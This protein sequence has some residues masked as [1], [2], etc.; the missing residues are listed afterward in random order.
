MPFLVHS[1]AFGLE[2]VL[3][4]AVGRAGHAL[5]PGGAVSW[6]LAALAVGTAIALWGVFAAPKSA[7]RL[8]GAALVLFKLAAFA[9]GAAALAASGLP[10]AAALYALL[11]AFYLALALREDAL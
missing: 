10:K 8:T 6:L 3:L 9:A 1:L 5:G 4:Y 7:R 11:A 2:A